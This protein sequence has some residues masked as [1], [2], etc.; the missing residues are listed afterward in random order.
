MNR[1]VSKYCVYYPTTVL[2]GENVHKYIQH[3]ERSQWLTKAELLHLQN[4]K[5]ACLL[6]YVTEHVP[7]YRQ[8]Y[9]LLDFKRLNSVTARSQLVSLPYLTK[10]ELRATREALRPEQRYFFTRRKTTGGSSG[11][12]VTVLKTAKAMAC[13]R[14]ATWR[15]YTWAGVGI[16]DM[17]GRFWVKQPEPIGRGRR[18]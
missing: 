12:P 9:S 2:L 7:F 6:K 3:Y 13:E 11:E 14:A 18:K 8:R 1:Y 4:S 5:L 10:L 17:Q 15:A 16:G